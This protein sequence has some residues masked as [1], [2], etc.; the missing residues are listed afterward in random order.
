M[1][2]TKT[3]NSLKIKKMDITNRWAQ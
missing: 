3:T 2:T 1:I